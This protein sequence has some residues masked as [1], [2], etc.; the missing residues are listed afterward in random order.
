MLLTLSYR[1]I[2]RNK[3]RTLITAASIMFA[4]F[5]NVVMLSIQR[6]SWQSMVDSVVHFYFGYAQIHQ[7]G[8]W[9]D[10]S[11]DNSLS[12][13]EIDTQALLAL[14][15][16]DG[17]IP[18]LESFA[19]ASFG[20][21]SKGVLFIGIEP[22]LEEGLTHLNA[23]IVSGSFFNQ[24]G[25][26]LA[27]GLAEYL[28]VDLGDSVVFIS[29]GYHGANAVGLYPVT[30]IVH[31]PAPDLDKQLAFLRLSDAQWFYGTEDRV[32]SLVLKT[33]NPNALTR[34]TDALRVHLN[35]EQYEVM[36]YTEMIPE[37]LEA[38]AYDEAG[39]KVILWLLYIIIAFGIFGTMLMMMKEREYEFGILKAI[40]MKSRQLQWMVW[41]EMAILMLIGSMAGIL[42]A[43]PVVWYL[44]MY[45]IRFTGKM[46]EAY[47]KFGVNAIMP[48]MIDPMIFLSQ[49][50]VVLV[51]VTIMTIY[52]MWLLNK[53]KPVRAMHH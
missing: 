52:P 12:L 8:Y 24:D 47:E 40:G 50:I 22:H 15:G 4:V 9:Q 32:T 41:T 51:L 39:G 42:I 45:P 14:P 28:K 43:Y 16:V 7:K 1:N 2:W 19:L 13:T 33:K 6:G 29:Q 21:Q 10:Q 30:G 23:R 27:Q 26:V 3:R 5:F 48:A 36:D 20:T 35:A 25:V 44:T 46:A 31:F 49:V 53:L 34:T 18:R 17:L 37:L 11:I 38:K